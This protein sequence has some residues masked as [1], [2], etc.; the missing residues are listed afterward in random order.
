[1]NFQE[2]INKG[3]DK[4]AFLE[5]LTDILSFT[6]MH[7]VKA[8][9][10]EENYEKDSEILAMMC[11]VLCQAAFGSEIERGD[12]GKAITRHK[13]KRAAQYREFKNINNAIDEARSIVNGEEE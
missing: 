5:V 8:S 11:T 6:S 4:E 9:K 3:R 12:L 13:A 7:M 1:M 2:K 10:S